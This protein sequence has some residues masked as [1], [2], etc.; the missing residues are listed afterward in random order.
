MRALEQRY[1]ARSLW[2]DG[3]PGSLAPR[4]S[5]EGDVDCDVAIVGAGL[6]G[7]LDRVCA[8]GP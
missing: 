4:P 7:L 5:L 1:R 6:I 8:C 2:L 3:L